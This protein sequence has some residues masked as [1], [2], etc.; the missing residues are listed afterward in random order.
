MTLLEIL[1][2]ISIGGDATS[3]TFQSSDGEDDISADE[4][5]AFVCCY[6]S[7]DWDGESYDPEAVKQL[8]VYILKL[9]DT[10]DN[11]E[12]IKPCHEN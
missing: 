8:C 1:N 4:A 3:I 9:F 10:I 5:R 7:D 6:L 12:T 11:H 2:K